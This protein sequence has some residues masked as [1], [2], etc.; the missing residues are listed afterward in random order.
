MSKLMMRL[1]REDDGMEM[2]EWAVVAAVFVALAAVGWNLLG[3]G[4]SSSLST[5]AADI[6]AINVVP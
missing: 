1:W 2:L 4:L 6:G 3:T 5:A